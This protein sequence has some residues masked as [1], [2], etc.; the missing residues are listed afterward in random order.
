MAV[1]I[2]LGAQWGDEGKGKIVDLISENYDAIA[3]YQGGDN[4]GHTVVRGSLT[5]KFHLIPSGIATP[6]KTVVMGNGMVINLETLC[7][8]LDS[9]HSHKISTDGLKIS[10]RAFVILPVH[11]KE[12][13]SRE[14]G[15]SPIG[16]TGRGIGPAYQDKYRR[17]GIRIGDFLD[18]DISERLKAKGLTADEI[19]EQIRLFDRIKKYVCDS[20]TLLNKLQ[21]NGANIL[22]EGAQG[23]ML[24]IDFGTYPYVTSSSPNPAGGIMGT[25]LPINSVRKIIGV[26]KAYTTRVGRGPF[27]TELTDSLGDDIRK[28]GNEFGTTTGRP[29]RCGWLDLA[30]LKYAS[31][32]CGTT[33]LAIMKLDVL[34]GL[35]KIKFA[36]SYSLDGKEIEGYPSKNKDLERISVNWGETNGWAKS[37]AG[38]RI[39]N[40]LPSEAKDY[41]NIIENELQLPIKYISTSPEQQ[42]TI[43][44][45]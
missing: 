43:V 18:T 36:K 27:P 24:D 7:R 23:I 3:R 40:E 4:A 32:I 31:Q 9:L 13:L 21:K 10:E 2:L 6:G 5:L 16:T 33:E 37:I 39:F 19:K 22:L 41:L 12:D 34:S 8:E 29:R 20:I 42:D 30:Q 28:K 38:C 15:D 44:K 11:K 25:G 14:S 1:D 17:S 35:D 45:S 26:M